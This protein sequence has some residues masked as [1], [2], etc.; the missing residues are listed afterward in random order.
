MRCLILC[1]FSGW[2][3]TVP[4]GAKSR[5]MLGPRSAKSMLLTLFFYNSGACTRAGF[6]RW[7]ATTEELGSV[8]SGP[9][10]R[11][12][13]RTLR[14]VPFSARRGVHAQS[15]QLKQGTSALQRDAECRR[16]PPKRCRPLDVRALAPPLSHAARSS[17]I[18][19][20]SFA[21]PPPTYSNLTVPLVQHLPNAAQIFSLKTFLCQGNAPELSFASFLWRRIAPPSL[22]RR[23]GLPPKYSKQTNSEALPL[24]TNPKTQ[25]K[26]GF[27]PQTTD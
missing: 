19:F 23:V 26:K 22:Q 25:A 10:R 4:P 14:R 20:C 2:D 7:R 17:D 3:V 6:F 16:Q 11:V 12:P 18:S 15:K 1:F 8:P 13:L 21:G 27:L 5:A 24:Q 9:T